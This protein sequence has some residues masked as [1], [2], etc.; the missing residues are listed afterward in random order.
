[1]VAGH[2]KPGCLLCAERC[3]SLGRPNGVDVGT[4]ARF[5]EGAQ[6]PPS[7]GHT[8]PPP[9]CHVVRERGAGLR[10][11]CPQQGLWGGGRRVALVKGPWGLGRRKTTC[12]RTPGP[13]A[14]TPSLRGGG[15]QDPSHGLAPGAGP[16]CL[17]GTK[18]AGS[19]EG[20][21]GDRGG[22]GA[23]T[24]G[25]CVWGEVTATAGRRQRSEP[26]SLWRE[27]TRK[28]AAECTAPQGH[29]EPE[30]HRVELWHL[31]GEERGGRGRSLS[32]FLRKP[33][34]GESTVPC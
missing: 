25:G 11:L 2:G 16:S 29:P 30:P 28:Q 3:P 8:A 22:R 6:G 7:A 20:V 34:G 21:P 18:R 17:K 5:W 32:R 13:C 9:R 15:V 4:G 24:A 26:R 27:P 31:K 33:W 14:V 19:S 23:A 1:M 12:S 10:W